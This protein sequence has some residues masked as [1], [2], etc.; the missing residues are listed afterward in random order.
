MQQHGFT[1]IEVMLFFAVSGLLLVGVLATSSTAIN[2]QRYNDAVYSLEALVKQ[3]YNLAANTVNSRPDDTSCTIEY[4]EGSPSDLQIIP[5]STGVPPRGADDCVVLGRIIILGGNANNA[6]PSSYVT[7]TVLGTHE[8]LGAGDPIDDTDGDAFAGYLFAVE[9]SSVGESS[10]PWDT[11]I[12]S[13]A[14]IMTLRSPATGSIITYALPEWTSFTNRGIGNL[15]LDNDAQKQ[16]DICLDPNGLVA[17]PQLG[18]RLQAKASGS[19]AVQKLADG[20]CP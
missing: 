19:S 14:S 7:A 11:R 10:L 5:N 17:G 20:V 12:T 1:M 15:Y 18:I 16:R 8:Y 9:P 13:P 3:Q 4:E 6:D 2:R